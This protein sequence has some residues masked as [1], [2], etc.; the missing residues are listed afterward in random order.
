MCLL[1]LFIPPRLNVL[2]KAYPLRGRG[3]CN[4]NESQKELCGRSSEITIPEV[5]AHSYYQVVL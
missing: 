3:R 5:G 1:D 2:S 4:G